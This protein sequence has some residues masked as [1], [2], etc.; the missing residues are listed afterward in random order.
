M[1]PINNYSF[2]TFSLGHYTRGF[3]I[4]TESTT[5]ELYFSNHASS[6][7][8]ILSDKEEGYAKFTINNDVMHKFIRS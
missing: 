5:I 3:N 6:L 1:K 2:N 8:L 7:Y 4:R